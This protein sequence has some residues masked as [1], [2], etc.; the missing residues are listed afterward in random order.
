MSGA[1]ELTCFSCQTKMQFTVPVSRRDECESCRADVRVCKN[2]EFYDPKS[3]N[4]CRE[5]SADPVQEKERSNVCDYFTPS[6][7]NAAGQSSKDDLL[8]AAEA[9]F[10]KN[11]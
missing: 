1:F 10:K 5:P 4:E 3:Y 2:C 11:N 8:A 9:L 6:T 7:K